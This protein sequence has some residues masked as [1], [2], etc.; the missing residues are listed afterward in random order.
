[1]A[2]TDKGKGKLDPNHIHIS[3]S[4]SR[5]EGETSKNQ[6]EI[7]NTIPIPMDNE[8]NFKIHIYLAQGTTTVN[9]QTYSRR[10]KKMSQLIYH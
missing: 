1:M 9:L 4:P 7:N 5:E 8:I 6:G 3:D 10:R 2:T